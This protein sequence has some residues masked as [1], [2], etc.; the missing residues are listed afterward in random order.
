[1]VAAALGAICNVVLNLYWIPRYGALGSAIAT[2]VARGCSDLVSSF[3]YKQ[4]WNSG[5]MQLKAL[6]LP[7]SLMRLYRDRDFWKGK[8]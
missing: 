3:L 1:M 2:M 8:T 7:G 6:F 5:I 4:T